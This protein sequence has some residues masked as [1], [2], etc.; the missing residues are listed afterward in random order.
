MK[1]PLTYCIS[2]ILISASGN[3]AVVNYVVTGY[4]AGSAPIVDTGPRGTP[5]FSGANA[6]CGPTNSV[7]RAAD[8][9]TFVDFT[10]GNAD[11]ISG[12]KF[13]S[14]EHQ[15]ASYRRYP[16]HHVAGSV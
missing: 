11:L 16:T 12:D 4:A 13:F 2:A 10:I 9:G 6:A 8:S 14:S 15:C 7:L 5:D 1:S 3:A